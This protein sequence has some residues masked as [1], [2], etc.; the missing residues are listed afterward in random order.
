[1]DA[2]WMLNSVMLKEALFTLQREPTIDL[3]ASRLNAQMPLYMSFR[4]DPQAETVDAFSVPWHTL[5]WYAFPPFSVLTQVLAKVQ[6]ER[7]TGVLVVPR[8][9]TQ[10]WWPLL[11][12]M[13]V[14]EPVSLRG[15]AMLTLPSNP[16]KV[17]PLHPALTLLV[18]VVSGDATATQ[19]FPHGQR[20]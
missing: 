10:V 4:P 9:P 15:K 20:T 2:E 13:L 14:R 19:A 5:N 6:R 1:M 11:T 17:H 8:W 12:K 18:C 3:F 7:A 16:G